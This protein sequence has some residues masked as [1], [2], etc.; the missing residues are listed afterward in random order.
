MGESGCV[1]PGFGS[2]SGLGVRLLCWM[3]VGLRVVVRVRMCTGVIE[4]TVAYL[5][6]NVCG[7]WLPD[8]GLYLGAKAFLHDFRSGYDNTTT[9][10]FA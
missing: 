2:V 10:N 4:E 8:D 7:C 9:R 1:Q 3:R 6:K 5:K